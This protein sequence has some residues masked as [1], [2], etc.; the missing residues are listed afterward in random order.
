M[1][2]E[3][4]VDGDINK[5]KKRAEKEKISAPMNMDQPG[6]S[7]SKGNEKV[8]KIPFFKLFS[9]ADKT[10]VILMV[11]G[12]IGAIANG[13][14]MPLMAIFYGEMIDSFGANQNADIVSVVT[15]VSLF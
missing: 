15:K 1:A 11:L 2:G 4:G 9:F 5:S 3:N 7:D 12:T 10:D 13:S 8:E 6:S 14:S